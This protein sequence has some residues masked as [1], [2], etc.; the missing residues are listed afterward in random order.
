MDLRR[1]DDDFISRILNI[2]DAV[3]RVFRVLDLFLAPHNVEDIVPM[4]GQ[5]RAAQT[6]FACRKLV[7]DP[8]A[9]LAKF[10]MRAGWPLDPLPMPLVIDCTALR[11]DRRFVELLRLLIGIGDAAVLCTAPA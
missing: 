1:R 10:F 11:A 7:V 2:H 6:H 9:S 5:E 8:V 3:Q 4:L